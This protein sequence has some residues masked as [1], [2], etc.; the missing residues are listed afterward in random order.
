MGGACSA[1]RSDF[2]KTA[3]LSKIRIKSLNT[4]VNVANIAQDMNA[5]FQARPSAPTRRVLNSFRIR[6]SIKSVPNPFGIRTSN[7]KDLKSFRIRTYEKTG[8][9]GGP[10]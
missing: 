4:Q 5:S 9:G 7:L 1:R 2:S 8:E 6:T 3:P 10:Q